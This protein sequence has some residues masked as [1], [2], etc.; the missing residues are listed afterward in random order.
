MARRE[1]DFLP[2]LIGILD[3]LCTTT[4]DRGE[5]MIAYFLDLARAEAADK[6]RHAGELRELET[7]LKQTSSRTSWRPVSPDDWMM[8]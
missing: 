7:K 1:A 4:S 8:A 3:R 6:L 5:H 2:A